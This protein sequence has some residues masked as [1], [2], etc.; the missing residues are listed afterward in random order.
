MRMREDEPLFAGPL[1]A[2]YGRN[3][4][5]GVISLQPYLYYTHD[6]NPTNRYW[7]LEV[8]FKWGI[9]QGIELEV[10]GDV[11]YTHRSGEHTFLYGD[12]DCYL[13]FQL[14]EDKKGSWEPDVRL[15]FGEIFPTGKFQ[16]L[17]PAL[18]GAD[19][20]GDGVFQTFAIFVMRKIFYN[21][22]HPY[23]WTLNLSYSIPSRRDIQGFN[24]YGG[25]KGTR[26]TV[27]PGNEFTADLAFEYKFDRAWGWAMDIYYV[28]QDRGSFHSRNPAAPLASL[29]FNDSLSLAPILEWNCSPHFNIIGGAW[30]TVDTR[31]ISPFT[32]WVI[33]A[34]F[35]F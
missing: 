1:I 14:S 28:H 22:E 29:P 17:D 27:R 13:G 18:N 25:G 5:P 3:T 24:V 32:T 23:N 4:N 21:G 20:T 9:T 8:E 7:Q 35:G 11:V 15:L 16:N 26:G 30:F 34:Y 31:N 6:R 10:E 12:T 2:F 19:G 33:S